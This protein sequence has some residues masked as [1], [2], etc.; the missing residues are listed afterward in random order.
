M[1]LR[2]IRN[3]FEREEEYYCKPVRAG[4]FWSNSYIE[5]KSKNDRKTLSPTKYLNKI[6]PYLR[7]HK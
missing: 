7:Y 1:I 4:D 2:D 6:R 3:L 5:Y